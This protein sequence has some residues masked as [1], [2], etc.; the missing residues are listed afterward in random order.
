M[1]AVTSVATGEELLDALRS[2]ATTVEIQG[3]I[4]GTPMVTLDPGVTVRG[5]TIR[6]GAKGI[7]MTSDNTIDGVTVVTAEDEVAILNDTS[8]SDLGTLTVRGVRATGQVH[9]LA[10][11]TVRSGHVHV[12][13]MTIDRADGRGRVERPHGFGV[14]ALQGAF[15]LWNRQEDGAGVLTAELLDIGVGTADSPV[16]GSGVSVGGHGDWQGGADGGTVRVSTL[17]TG[18]VHTDGGIPAGTPDLISGGVFVI[19]GADVAH[20]V[21][22]GPV[23]TNGPS[24][25]VLDNWGRMDGWTAESAVTSNGPGGSVGSV[26]IGGRVA[27]RGDN[28]V[29]VEIEGEVGA[30]DVAGG[31][32]LEGEGSDAVHVHGTVGGLSEVD[33]RADHGRRVVHSD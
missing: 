20:V 16:Q 1:S 13:G 19:T 25:V 12:E 27:T 22:A 15:T 32:V 3:S 17:R 11:D 14:E 33:I 18:E 9:L 8:V 4:S 7:R 5:G 2:G 28:V 10:Q 30:I 6:F 26:H 23:T 24:D 29:T 21:N 31:I